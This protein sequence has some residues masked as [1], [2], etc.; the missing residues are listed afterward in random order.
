MLAGPLPAPGCL[1]GG[2]SHRCAG[3]GTRKHCRASQQMDEPWL[4]WRRGKGLQECSR[5]RRQRAR[6]SLD[7]PMWLGGEVK[8]QR[9]NLS[10][11]HRS[12]HTEWGRLDLSHA[13]PKNGQCS[14][15]LHLRPNPAWSSLQL[16]CDVVLGGSGT[17]GVE[18][19]CPHGALISAQV[20]LQCLVEPSRWP[21]PLPPPFPAG[22]GKGRQWVAF[23]ECRAGQGGEKGAVSPSHE[24]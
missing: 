23:E 14:S 18:P 6:C 2:Q 4:R 24:S 8:G 13:A 12:V 22:E 17:S 19:P 9:E 1:Q 3:A 5:R 10:A 20:S 21:L 7:A 16:F 11:L 15:P